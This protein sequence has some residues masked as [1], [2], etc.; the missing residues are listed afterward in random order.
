MPATGT[1]TPKKATKNGGW[2][3]KLLRQHTTT[4][5]DREHGGDSAGR[6]PPRPRDGGRPSGNSTTAHR[7]AT[8]ERR[9]RRSADRDRTGSPSTWKTAWLGALNVAAVPMKARASSRGTTSCGPLDD[10]QDAE[11]QVQQ[12]EEVGQYHGRPSALG[13]HGSVHDPAGVD[14]QRPALCSAIQ[15]ISR[16]VRGGSGSASWWVPPRARARRPARPGRRSAR[17]ETTPASG[18]TAA[19]GSRVIGQVLHRARRRN[20]RSGSKGGAHTTS[21]VGGAHPRRRV[22]RNDIVGVKPEHRRHIPK[23][24]RSSNPKVNHHDQ[25]RHS[26]PAPLPRPLLWEQSP[27][28]ARPRRRLRPS[29]RRILEGRVLHR[30]DRQD[31]HGKGLTKKAK[32]HHAV[33]HRHPLRLQRLQRRPVRHRNRGRRTLIGKSPSTS[34]VETGNGAVISWPASSGLN[35]SNVA[36]TLL[37]PPARTIPSTSPAHVTSGAFT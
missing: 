32:T 37:G 26:S 33:L 6:R 15:L 27:W 1:S 22:P 23:T 12:A 13:G 28:P 2:A 24:T 35:P 3:M 31:H 19:S 20:K 8:P 5:A 4:A 14:G 10:Q 21:A 34:I 16:C 11:R 18:C 36:V 9:G 25:D 7:Y 29:A 17:P 30:T